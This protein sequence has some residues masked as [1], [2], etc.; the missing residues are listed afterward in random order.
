M[1]VNE[2]E[3]QAQDFLKK[4]NTKLEVRF[5][6]HNK[7][8]VGDKD[9]RDIFE[10]KLTRGTREYIFKYGASI[11]DHETM[12]KSIFGKNSNTYYAENV[13]NSK[14][15]EGR[16]IGEKMKYTKLRAKMSEWND[17]GQNFMPTAY[18]ILACLEGYC[19]PDNVDDFASEYGYEK[20]SEAIRVFEAVKAQADAL[21]KMFNDE[22]L[23]ELS[24]IS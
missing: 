16:A 9:E 1:K 24:N 6:E 5:L 7:Y 19:Y 23:E 10:A 17:A 3:Q 13:I 14:H 15:N 22:E 2:Y 4:T 8:F 18:D 12:L 20:P 11:A 21:Q